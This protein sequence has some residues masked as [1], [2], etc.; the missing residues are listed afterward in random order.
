MAL[1]KYRRLL[2][3][4]AM[5]FM[6]W[7]ADYFFP[8]DLQPRQG[9]QIIVDSQGEPLRRFA[10]NNG[11]WRYPISQ[12]Q[13]SEHYIQALLAYEDRWFYR[14]PGVNPVALGRAF[15]Q[16]L[17]YGRIISGGSTLTMQVARLRYP[18]SAG[19]QHGLSGKLVQLMRA[20]QLEW[21]FSKQDILHY[22][23][24]HAP[25]G[26]T[27][28]GV[29]TASRH[30]FGHSARWLTQAQAAL[31]A[32]L[33][34][35]PS[36]YRPDR[37][38]D[39]AI[40]Q[41]NKVLRR[42]VQFDVLTEEQLL[43]AEQEDLSLNITSP[44]LYAPLL[45]RQLAG[46]YPQL[47]RI[48]SY[49][50]RDLQ[51]AAQQIA[52]DNRS[53]LPAGASV[54]MLVMEHGSGEIKAHVGSAEF[55]DNS[56]FGHVDMVNALRSPGSTLKPFIFAR[57]LDQGLIHSESLLMDVPLVFNDY[58][59]TNFD[60][61][62]S[63]AVSAST[64]LQQSLNIPAVQLLDQL[65]PRA[66]YAWLQ[67]AGAQLI[68][69]DN[70]A[71][72]LAMALGGVDIRLSNLVSLYS[73]LG[74]NGK[75]ITPLF[76]RQQKAE[77]K[78]LMTPAAAW[79]VRDILLQGDQRRFG[80]SQPLAI[81]TG[82]SSGY[83][84]AW[85]LAVTDQ[86]TVGVWVGMPNNAT[87]S[88]HYGAQTAVP[89]LRAL[90]SRLPQ[91]DN[92]QLTS[93]RRPD[94]VAA[95]VIC[96]PGGQAKAQQPQE[97]CDQAFTAWT[98][99]KKTPLTLMHSR[100]HPEQDAKPWV[101]ILVATDSGKRVDLG[102]VADSEKQLYPRWPA[103]LQNWIN[104]DWR[105]YQRL[106]A[107]DSRCKT[108]QALLPVSRLTIQG[109]ENNQRIKRH[110]TTQE[111]PLLH[112]RVVGGQPDWYWFLN[113]E[114]LAERGSKLKLTLPKPGYYQLSVVDQAGQGDKVE[115]VVEPDGR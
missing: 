76:S 82:T 47:Q 5:L 100:E 10:D 63:G 67:S 79:I 59:P 50:N 57:A 83:R 52:A 64:A 103:P 81:K 70:V 21:H 78:T 75:V 38:P 48:D 97:L 93:H 49:I 35:A 6:L 61:G 43:R 23:L 36:F 71:P 105:S 108:H 90:V 73:A 8:V 51:W 53:V 11:V 9:A 96:W 26:G 19:G 114:L 39:R 110:Q 13:V 56:R 88:G 45:A 74:N 46:Q 7:L 89:L 15:Y 111:L 113:G 17:K 86:Y 33:P 20:V 2:F 77:V 109:I 91:A 29:E 30:Y 66:F 16:W 104:P 106:P 18:A 95:Q 22:Y 68:L 94:N 112:A 107:L 25:F 1:N 27:I 102:C 28:E 80:I 14:H 34:Q 31:L 40:K 42:M 84:D 3:L 37:H 12:S 92:S 54:A 32:G 62:F 65:E 41:R 60:V 24:N 58:R 87:M 101:E 99:N 55:S 72:S 4:P 69:P 44:P 85:A 115:F 98:I